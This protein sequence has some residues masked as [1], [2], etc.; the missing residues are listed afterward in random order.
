MNLNTI[1]FL[2]LVV[3]SK[4]NF[5]YK[6]IYKKKT[7]TKTKRSGASGKS[8]PRLHIFL[9]L[10]LLLLYLLG[11]KHMLGNFGVHSGR[12]ILSAVLLPTE[13]M[14]PYMRRMQ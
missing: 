3:V 7:K 4:A 11:K 2:A 14:L 1:S 10:L 12:T 9:T 5:I 6:I 13:D 8:K